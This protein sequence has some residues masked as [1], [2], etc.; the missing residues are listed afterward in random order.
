MKA[1]FGHLQLAG[2]GSFREAGG[3]PLS[4][5]ARSAPSPSLRLNE[6]N[7]LTWLLAPIIHLREAARRLGRADSVSANWPGVAPAPSRTADRE[8]PFVTCEIMINEPL[9]KAEDRAVPGH[10]EAA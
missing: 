7:E 4:N 10:W 3:M 5:L 1:L 8:K 6:R 2:T 9:A